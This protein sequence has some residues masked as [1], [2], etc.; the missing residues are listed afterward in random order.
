MSKEQ[1]LERERA[2]ATPAAIAGFIAVALLIGSFVARSQIPAS[3]NT[4]TQLLAFNDHPSQLVLSS[5]L[6]GLGFALFSI[7]LAFLFQAARARSERV[8]PLL[9]ALCFVGPV[10]IG[11]QG[12]ING[13]G[14]KTA[15]ADYAAMPKEAPKPLA[16][17]TKELDARPPTISTVNVYTDSNQLEIETV[18]GDFYSVN[19]QA[20]DEK[21]LIGPSTDSVDSTSEIGKADVDNSLTS[22]GKIG[23]ARASK[24]A[25][26]NS[27]VKLA[28][29]LIFPAALAMIVAVVYTALQSYR[30]GLLSRFFG[31]LGM[32]LGAALILLPQA[33]IFIA[34]WLGW[35]GL[36]FIDR[37][38]N[39]RPPAWAAGEAIPWPSPGQQQ[40][41]AG[42]Q[43]GG[44]DAIE[45]SGREAGGENGA[46]SS[47]G[48]T[49][50]R[51]RKRRR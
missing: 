33:P 5:I 29:N 8:Q 39:G 27:T 26:D 6:S 12:V 36:I 9:I 46:G 11:V 25:D 35:L 49:Q 10:L 44:G 16:E 30:V 34:L 50:K 21:N 45:G 43:R 40:R 2:R 41:G 32:A 17:F 20:S 1:I 37:V 48:P 19:Y 24:V 4:S 51:K 7:P 28:T 38:P 3:S 23:D 42:R 31:T 22:D 47:P 18:K 13:F 14:L 15:A